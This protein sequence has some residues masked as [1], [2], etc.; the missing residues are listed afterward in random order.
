MQAL[1]VAVVLTVGSLSFGCASDKKTGSAYQGDQSTY[2]Y[3]SDSMDRDYNV[4]RSGSSFSGQNCGPSGS[5]YQ[6]NTTTAYDNTY[7]VRHTHPM[8]R[9]D[10]CAAP[11]AECPPAQKPVAEKPSKG[12]AFAGEACPE[13]RDYWAD[14]E[15]AP[16]PK[17]AGMAKVDVR[18][19]ITSVSYRI[20][21]A[22]VDNIT[23]AFLHL[24]KT[25]NKLGPVIA[26]LYQG[27]AKSGALKGTLSS[28]AIT[29]DMLSGPMKGRDLSAF[30]DEIRRGNVFVRVTTTQQ[31]EGVLVGKLGYNEPSEA[32]RSHFV[33]DPPADQMDPNVG[34]SKDT[35]DTSGD[36]A[37]DRGQMFMATLTP[38]REMSDAKANL[39]LVSNKN[40]DELRYRLMLTNVKNPT[41][42]NLYLIETPSPSTQP[43]EKSVTGTVERAV[44]GATMD[45]GEPVAKLNPS[46]EIKEGSFSG[47]FAQ[48]TLTKNDLTGALKDKD[49]STL[50]DHIKAGHIYVAVTTD[51]YRPGQFQGVVRIHERGAGGSSFEGEKLDS[52]KNP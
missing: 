28:G 44:G 24:G 46:K 52:S 38:P 32:T 40:N 31:P 11:K 49:V 51:Q 13:S 30:A 9:T 10:A 15:P 14:L 5:A 43:S 21:V 42:A 25:D 35:S 1:L 23:G 37:R 18:T 26:T 12:A 4:N 16:V 7:S 47:V 48:G 39:W 2:L 41:G 27:E 22:N 19:G 17:P 29:S 45:L 36:F 50:I 20:D 3:T 34:A 8:G 33:G 6:Q